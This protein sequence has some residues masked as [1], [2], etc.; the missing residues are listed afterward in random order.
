[1]T[2]VTINVSDHEADSQ[3][4][5]Y[6]RTLTY[7][8]DGRPFGSIEPEFRSDPQFDYRYTAQH[9]ELLTACFTLALL[10]YRDVQLYRMERPDF[11]ITLSNHAEAF[12][13]VTSIIDKSSAQYGAMLDQLNV[14][15]NKLVN[16]ELPFSESLSDQFA[17]VILPVA[18]TN[19]TRQAIL[20]ELKAIILAG[21]LSRDSPSLEAIGPDFP[22]LHGARAQLFR[23]TRGTAGHFAVRG[24]ARAVGPYDLIGLTLNRL[25]RKLLQAKGYPGRPLWLV[26]YFT[27]VLALYDM[28]LTTLKEIK[29]DTISPFERVLIGD[30]RRM[31]EFSVR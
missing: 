26:L 21:D 28:S 16:T 13:E 1:M 2:G 19:K 11:R 14:E 5:I 25:K 15:I 18:P 29:M 9:A 22:I 20:G 23:G 10:G 12:L 17:E 8:I 24:P 27:E 30:Q 3:S 6:R 31:I 4:E 7:H